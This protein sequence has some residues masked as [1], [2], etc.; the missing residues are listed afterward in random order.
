[1]TCPYIVNTNVD[2]IDCFRPEI[3]DLQSLAGARMIDALLM[4]A[5]SVRERIS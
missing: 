4:E 5:R 1:M 3:A 2:R